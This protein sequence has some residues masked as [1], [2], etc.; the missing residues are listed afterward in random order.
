MADKASTSP[1]ISLART[2]ADISLLLSEIPASS[3]TI[4][5]SP[6]GFSTLEHVCHMRDIEIE[7]YGVRIQRIL[8][9]ANPFLPD[10]DGSRL[11]IE[12]DYNRQSLN[13]AV[14][15]FTAARRQNLTML[16]AASKSDFEK[17][18]E[19]EG[20]GIV[21]LSR[22]VEMM[23]EHDEGHLEEMQS[24]SRFLKRQL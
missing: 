15:A 18:G 7:G 4:K 1:L 3:I 2:P 5:Q 22:L 20:V 23:V 9:E 8:S 16:N 19:L 24:L 21:N 13:D 12:R 14:P 10:I 17:E 11:A 6:D